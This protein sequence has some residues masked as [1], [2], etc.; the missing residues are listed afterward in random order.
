MDLVGVPAG[1]LIVLGLLD[2]SLDRAVDLRAGIG[3][4]LVAAGADQAMDWQPGGLPGNVP[5]RDIDGADRADRRDAGAPPQQPVEPL[6][7][8]RVLVRQDRLQ[9]AD[10]AGTVEA[11]RVRRGAQKRVSLDPL[12]GHDP[13]QAKIAF[14]RGP[15]RVVAVN[16]RGDAFPRE[17]GQ[18][19]IGDL[20]ARLSPGSNGSVSVGI[21]SRSR[22]GLNS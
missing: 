10:Q 20:H 16:R 15:R 2:I 1:G 18:R 14:P 21:K 3:A 7:V 22:A 11:R 9:K 13:Q 17:Q 19:D 12:V 6:A 8:E 5:Q 4:D